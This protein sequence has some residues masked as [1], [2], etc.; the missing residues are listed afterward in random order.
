M[1]SETAGYGE[2]TAHFFTKDRYRLPQ[3]GGIRTFVSWP[4]RV[5]MMTR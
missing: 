4:T 3:M 2:D 1:G 5:G